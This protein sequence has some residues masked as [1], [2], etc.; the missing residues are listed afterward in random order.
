M[1]SRFP[2][3]YAPSLESPAIR[4]NVVNKVSDHLRQSS[5]LALCIAVI[6][7]VSPLLGE[8]SQEV[9]IENRVLSVRISPEGA[10]LR[11]LIAKETGREF[12][13]HGDPKFEKEQCNTPYH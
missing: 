11:S 4:S 6:G 3:L 13:W 5:Q 8:E 2:S 9:A 7:L 10:E 12:L 1:N